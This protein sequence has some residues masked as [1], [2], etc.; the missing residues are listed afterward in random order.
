LGENPGSLFSARSSIADPS[1]P[2]LK[3]DHSAHPR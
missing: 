3:G 1:T 2:S